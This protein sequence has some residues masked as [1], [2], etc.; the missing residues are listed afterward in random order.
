MDILPTCAKLAGA[1]L[2]AGRE[3]D[4]ADLGAALF[5]GDESREALFFYYG[6]VTVRAVRKGPWK[7]WV[8]DPKAGFAQ[9]PARAA[10]PLLFHV[11]QDPADRV[12]VA[13]ENPGVVRGLTALVDLHWAAVALG[14]VPE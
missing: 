2:A 4:G 9:K 12:N 13:D 3:L 11:E 10:T 1:R 6:D 14:E 5:R 8:T 7:L